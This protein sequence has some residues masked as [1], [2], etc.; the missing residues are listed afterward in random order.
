MQKPSTFPGAYWDRTGGVSDEYVVTPINAYQ[1]T[2]N[3][4]YGLIVRGYDYG[5]RR[6][7]IV[8]IGGTAQCS[9]TGAKYVIDND[10]KFDSNYVVYLCTVKP[11][12][13]VSKWKMT[14]FGYSEVES[15]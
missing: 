3:T 8:I 6:W 12:D 7:V 11:Q 5:L 10:G 13:D 9:A 15:G 4:D 2:P 1:W 14:D